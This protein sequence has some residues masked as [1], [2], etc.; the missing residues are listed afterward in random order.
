MTN[1]RG[2]PQNPEKLL[3][4][5]GKMPWVISLACNSSCLE[6]QSPTELVLWL[7]MFTATPKKQFRHNSGLGV[8][9][10]LGEGAQGGHGQPQMCLRSGA[11]WQAGAQRW[12]QNS[13]CCSLATQ[14]CRD[15]FFVSLK[16]QKGT[17]KEIKKDNQ[18][19]RMNLVWGER[20]W[21][22]G[23]LQLQK[24]CRTGEMITGL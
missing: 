21:I 24:R 4:G 23:I 7:V 6:I 16:G 11:P 20:Q 17:W 22:N 2:I 9:Y 15:F 13:F 5:V 1:C 8:G 14:M 10:F 18:R 12:A 3:A 19:H